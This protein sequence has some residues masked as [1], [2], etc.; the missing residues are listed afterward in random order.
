MKIIY[1]TYEGDANA[2]YFLSFLHSDRVKIL[3]EG[4]MAEPRWIAI[5]TVMETGV[6]NGVFCLA[7][8]R[9]GNIAPP[10]AQ[11]TPFKIGVKPI[12]PEKISDIGKKTKEALKKYEYCMVTMDFEK[13]VN[14]VPEGLR[15][16]F[17][18]WQKEAKKVLA[19]S[20]F[21]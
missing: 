6:I 13:I 7:S 1:C 3:K 2:R 21:R 14:T 5:F 11:T 8:Y 18:D 9:L 4:E 15:N 16:Q 12:E 17:L 10:W 20:S 19:N